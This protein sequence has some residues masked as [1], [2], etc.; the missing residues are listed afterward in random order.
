MPSK[1]GLLFNVLQIV[2]GGLCVCLGMHYFV[3]FLVLQ[4]TLR[5][6]ERERERER[7]RQRERERESY[8]FCF[9]CLTDVLFL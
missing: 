2:C 4:S 3:P 7:D 8:L 6:R 9:Y 5:E 1:S